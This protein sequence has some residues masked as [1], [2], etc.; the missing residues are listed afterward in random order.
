MSEY[1]EA[2]ITIPF[3]DHLVSQLNNISPRLRLAVVRTRK[4]EEIPTEV[5]ER[6][7]VLYT[8]VVLPIP[9]QVPN[10]RWLQFHW[11]GIDHA[12]NHPLLQKPGLVITN[13]SGVGSSQMAEYAVMTALALGHRLPDLIAHQRR[14]E[15]PKD[16]WERFSPLEL[17]GSTVG[18]VGYGSIGRQ[19]ARLMHEFGPT[20]L[21]TKRDVLHPAD[22]D[23]V[24][25]GMGDPEGN[26]IHR[27]YPPQALTSMLRECDFV[28]VTVPLTAE[29]HD[30]IGA[31][32]LAVLKPTAFVIDLSRGGILDHAALYAALRDQKLAGAAL[33]VFPEEPLPSDSP[34]W[35]M[36]NVI[37]TP[38]IS[39]NTPYYDER[40]V[41]FFSENL[42]RYLAGLS[43]YNRVDIARGY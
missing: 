12:I 1:V 35:K 36:P 29:T 7:E 27:L 2:L 16:R 41:A 25:E 37:L 4:V 17:R 8:N 30:L 40:A 23:Y 28:I 43:L 32:E 5:L 18:I 26:F 14:S 20:L 15:W 22:T 34:L 13:L 24:P 3:A 42:H 33:D 39:G 11:T 31:K 10:L 6:A 9:D 21:A 19:I 38:H